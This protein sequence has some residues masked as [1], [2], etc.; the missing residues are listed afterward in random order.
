MRIEST[1]KIYRKDIAEAPNWLE[2][3]LDPLN[4]FM[5]S[6]TTALRGKLTFYDNVYCETKEF[7]FT[8]GVEQRI[9]HSLK[10]YSGVIMIKG[11]DSTAAVDVLALPLSVRTIDN[12]TLGI[13][14]WFS[15]VGA[16]NNIK[17]IILG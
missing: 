10:S 9:S 2:K 11:P 14:A 7:E 13:T 12:Q 6:C 5:D 15:G 17:F 4:R 16:T 1:N 8:H 3:L